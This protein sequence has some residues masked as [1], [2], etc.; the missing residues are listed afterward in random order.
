MVEIATSSIQMF[1]KRYLGR[2]LLP[3][4][5]FHLWLQT[6]GWEEPKIVSR[7]WLAGIVLALFGLWLAL[8]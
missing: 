7:S 1:G 8:L 3:I 4:S 5:P 6:L 2:R